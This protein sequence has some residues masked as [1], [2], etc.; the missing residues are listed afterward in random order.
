MFLRFEAQLNGNK[1][2]DIAPELILRDIVESP[3]EV[4]V[5]K[6]RYANRPGQRVSSIVRTS[7]SVRLV[8]VIRSRDIQRRME[9]RD[10]IVAWAANGGTLKVNTRPGKMLRVICETSPML[11][12]SLRWT[13]DLSLTLTAYSIPYWQDEAATNL[14]VISAVPE[15]G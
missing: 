13:Q 1:F 4:D 11:E 2:S 3:A 8:Y 12:S 7:L 10:L 14:P 15:K 9:I 6:V 5:S